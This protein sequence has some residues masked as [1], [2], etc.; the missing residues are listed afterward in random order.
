M[1]PKFSDLLRVFGRIGL[2]SFGGPA[3]QIALMHQELVEKRP[4]L[5]EDQFLRGLSFCMLL[6][7]PE[8]M[9]LATYAGW[10]LRGIWG[11][12]LAGLLFVIPGAVAIAFLCAIYINY[13][14]QP[15]IQ[16][17]FMG[18]K[19]AVVT[20]VINALLKL[21]QK[22]L[23]Q[24]G[25]WV[26]AGLSAIAL[27]LF[28]LPFPLV[29]LGGGVVGFILAPTQQARPAQPEVAQ[30]PTGLPILLFWIGLWLLPLVALS[31]FAAPF[32]ASVGWFFA[33]LAVVTFG[34]AYAVLAYMSQA[35]VDQNGWISSNQMLDALGLAETTPGPLILVTQFVA[36]LS[37]QIAGGLPYAIAA[38]L[39]ALWATFVPC[40][41]WVFAAAPHVE[42]LT[43]HP[44]IGQALKSITACIVGVIFNLSIWFLLNV[45]FGTIDGLRLGPATLPLPD[46][47]TLDLNALFL[48]LLAPI[49]LR[50]TKGNLFSL[51]ALMATAGVIV[52]Y[53]TIG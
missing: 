14:T 1:T 7:G 17:S 10:R 53:Y 20:V 36:M 2:L 8:A 26:C 52:Q 23:N 18:I 25:D 4:W 9:Q 48:V 5:R 13:G 11:G 34:G 21:Q 45:L 31:V 44:R 28:D 15:I 27:L 12:V 32:L 41:L 19:A 47:S 40:F 46:L 6:P 30:S 49:L 43:T 51:L 22:A 42:R 24:F 29:I 33:K 16:S 39:I 50:V 38:G 37:G 3:A 35:V